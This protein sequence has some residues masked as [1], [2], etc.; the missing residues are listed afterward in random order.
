MWLSRR[1]DVGLVCEI[2]R[3]GEGERPSVVPFGLTASTELNMFF[4]SLPACVAA[5]NLSLLVAVLRSGHV[6]A[7]T[8]L[9][10][11]RKGIGD[12]KNITTTRCEPNMLKCHRQQW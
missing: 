7:Y 5:L 6:C 10:S 3:C 12:I 8:V 9:C 1:T 11:E 2:I 4:A